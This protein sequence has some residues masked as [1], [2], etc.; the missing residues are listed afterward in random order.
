EPG[1]DAREWHVVTKVTLEVQQPIKGA[2]K[3]GNK[4]D[5]L[6]PGG[7]MRL[8]GKSVCTSPRSGFYQ[9]RFGDRIVVA[10]G[11]SAGDSRLLEAPYV[12][13]LDRNTIQPEPYPALR[14]EQGPLLLDRL[15]DS[16]STG[17]F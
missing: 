10:A 2:L 13:R 5:F 9:P 15:L 16:S 7:S 6:S 4:I 11:L 8:A 1:W 17:T 12:F 3:A 14:A